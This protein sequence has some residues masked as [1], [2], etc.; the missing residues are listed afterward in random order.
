M[1]NKITISIS[2]AL[3]QKLEEKIKGTNFKSIQEYVAFVLEQVTSEIKAER[4]AHTKEE[5]KEL[6]GNPHTKEE[7]DIAGSPAY[8]EKEEADCSF[9]NGDGCRP[10]L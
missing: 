6:I 3:K 9:Y 10:C 2:K 8:T 5:E 1:T 4:Q 7:E